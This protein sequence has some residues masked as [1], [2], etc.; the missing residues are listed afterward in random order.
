MTRYYFDIR[1]GEA[2]IRDQE[3]AEFSDIA[4]AKCDAEDAAR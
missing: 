4:S 3:G 1:Q 2:L